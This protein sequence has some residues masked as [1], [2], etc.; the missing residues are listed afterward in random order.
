M[1]PECTA[2]T[3]NGLHAS[4][5]IYA[6]VSNHIISGKRMEVFVKRTDEMRR[7]LLSEAIILGYLKGIS[8]VRFIGKK[9]FV[10]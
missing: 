6:S 8:S 7:L 4:L 5:S 9:T 2:N 10:N 1:H 3:R